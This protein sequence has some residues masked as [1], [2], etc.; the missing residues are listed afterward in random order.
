MRLR[1]SLSVDDYATSFEGRLRALSF[2]HDQSFAGADGGELRGLIEAEAGMH[3]F[4]QMPDRITIGGDL[5]GLTERAFGVFA[6]LLH[7][8]MTN[9]AKY[10]SLSV[11]SGKLESHGRSAS[12]AIANLPGS[13]A[14][15]RKWSRPPDRASERT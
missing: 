10:G 8:M 1:D 6:L 4:A 3:R 9:S 12:M 15:A 2:A 7:E 11:P 13:K 5:V 14:G